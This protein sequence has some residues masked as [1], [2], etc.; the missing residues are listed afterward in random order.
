LGASA[1]EAER[2]LA[3]FVDVL[4][5]ALVNVGTLVDVLS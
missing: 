2:P 3:L 5:G 4:V 1:L